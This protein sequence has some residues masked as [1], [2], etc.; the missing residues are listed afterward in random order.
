MPAKYTGDGNTI[1]EGPVVCRVKTIL[2][3]LFL[4]SRPTRGFAI[5]VVLAHW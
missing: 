5:H 3:Q 1:F 2:S 4:D